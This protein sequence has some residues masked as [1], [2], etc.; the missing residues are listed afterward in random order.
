MTLEMI[1]MGAMTV[2]LVAVIWVVN[3]R[4]DKRRNGSDYKGRERR[5][6]RV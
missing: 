3:K 2:A 5:L 1:L 4:L 6:R